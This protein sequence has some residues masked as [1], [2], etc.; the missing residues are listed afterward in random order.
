M[1]ERRNVVPREWWRSIN[2]DELE[3]FSIIKWL[4]QNGK[5]P[6]HIRRRVQRVLRWKLYRYI[7][8]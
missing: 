8:G 4:G 5:S 1:S 2:L 7:L 6:R 3:K